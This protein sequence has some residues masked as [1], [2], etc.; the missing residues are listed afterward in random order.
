MKNLELLFDA[1]WKV[2]AV[3]LLLGAGLPAIFAT[4]IRAMAYGQGG[5][6]E[7]DSTARPHPVGRVIG[8]LC[9]ALVAAAIIT[10]ITIIVASGFG[11]AVSFD[12]I[13]PTIVDKKH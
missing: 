8:I 3:G 6:A 9:F 2:L 1:A 11:K 10:G 13:I 5:S 12:H 7:I 4:G